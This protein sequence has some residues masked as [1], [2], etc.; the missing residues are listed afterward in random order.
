MTGPIVMVVI[1]D[2]GLPLLFMVSGA[3]VAVIL[4]HV[5]WRDG[6]K[7]FPGDERA[8]LNR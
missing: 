2:V 1:L 8:E 6:E 7:Q 3:L 4:G 5:L